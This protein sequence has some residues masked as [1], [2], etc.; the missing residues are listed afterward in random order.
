MKRHFLKLAAALAVALDSAAH[1]A[2]PDLIPCPAKINLEPGQFN[3]NANTAVTGDPVFSN[4]VAWLSGHL[5]LTAADPRKNR[6]LLTTEG[7]TALPNEGYQ[8]QVDGDGATIRATTSAGAFYGCQTLRQLVSSQTGSIP[9]IQINDAPRYAWRGLMLDVSRH[10]F[11]RAAVIRALDWMSDFKL[12]RLHLHLTDNE[13]WRLE[14]P[15]YPA[16]T[17]AGARGNYSDSNAPARYFTR[18]DVRELVAAA[19]VRHIVI[20][21]EIDTPGHAGAAL[22]A[23]P[24][25]DS[26]AHMFDP[27]REETYRFLENTLQDVM[28]DF[29]SPWIHF[30][31][32]EVNARALNKNA[33][34]TQNLEH[35]FDARLARFIRDQ[36]RIPAGWDEILAAAPVT[37]AVIYWWRHDKPQILAQALAGGYSVVLAPRTPCYF[38]YPQDATYPPGGW[39]LYNTLATVYHGPQI[40]KDL[41]AAQLKQILGVEACIWTERIASESYLEFMTLP[42]LAAFGEMAW[43]PDESRDFTQFEGR[44]KPFLAGYEAAGIHCY[45][46]ADPGGSLRNARQKTDTQAASI[47]VKRQ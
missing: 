24:N 45:D 3:L 7:A 35:I 22:R 20:V 12:N 38:D 9:Y 26:G 17:Q 31:G 39:K 11:D 10:F 6:I 41:P 44:L 37:N 28:A 29:P 4:E 43:S 27:A 25:L 19:A 14:I 23:M 36:G 8:L 42:R 46:P 30:G 13:G 15:Q 32:D 18:N 47:T 16:L 21:P 40:S 1:A 5:R 34:A 33:D 2:G